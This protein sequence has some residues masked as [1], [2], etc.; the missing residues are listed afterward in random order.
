MVT[1]A[2]ARAMEMEDRKEPEFVTFQKEGDSV[3][4]VLVRVEKIQ[5]KR[6]DTNIPKP[7]VRF[8]VEEIDSGRR[9]AFLGTYQLMTML[10]R[11]DIGKVIAVRYTGKRDIPSG[12]L[13]TFDVQVSKGKPAGANV[14]G[15]M[16]SGDDL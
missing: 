7:A 16:I 10:R 5:V 15:D 6:K 9:L 8:T 14:P 4:G 11:S 12:A 2:E 3:C 13:T 1:L